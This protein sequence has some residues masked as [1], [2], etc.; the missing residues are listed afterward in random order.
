MER[1][2][3]PQQSFIP[4]LHII[5]MTAKYD[6]RIGHIPEESISLKMAEIQFFILRVIN[7][8]LQCSNQVRLLLLV[9]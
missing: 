9:F 2:L 1:L 3:N 5:G 7:G 8:V 6:D 4:I